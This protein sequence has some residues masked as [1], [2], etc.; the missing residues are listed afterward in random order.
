MRWDLKTFAEL[1]NE[2]LFDVVQLRQEVF[3]IEQDCPYPD[4]DYKDKLSHHL[5][6]FDEGKLV[7]YTRLVPYGVSFDDAL[8]IGRVVVSPAAR[9]QGLAYKL[10]AESIDQLGQLYG[11]Q[12]ITIGAQLYLKRFYEQV[13]FVQIT[14][15]YDEDGIPHIDMTFVVSCRR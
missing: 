1:T 5:M 6:C 9:G 4:V 8:S 7:A 2:E 14:D 10:M 3:I 12:R 11:Q 13:G 15:E